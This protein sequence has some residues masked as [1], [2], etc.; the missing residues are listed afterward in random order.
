[1]KLPYV[2]DAHAARQGLRCARDI[3]FWTLKVLP[4]NDRTPH[5]ERLTDMSAQVS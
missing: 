4:F 1:M 5:V 2:P 3:E